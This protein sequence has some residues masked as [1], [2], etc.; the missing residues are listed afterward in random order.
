[1]HERAPSPPDIVC[2]RAPEK[3]IRQPPVQD[4]CSFGPP[5]RPGGVNDI[6]CIPGPRTS[7][8]ACPLRSLERGIRSVD[9]LRIHEGDVHRAEKAGQ[10]LRGDHVRRARVF[11]NEPPAIFRERGIER[12]ICAP[13]FEDPEET[14]HHFA[15]PL[16]R[17]PHHNLRSHAECRQ[18]A[19]EEVCTIVQV[20]VAPR[21]APAGDRHGLR[22]QAGLSLDELVDTQGWSPGDPGRVPLQKYP[23][24]FLRGQERDLPHAHIVPARRHRRQYRLEMPQHPFDGRRGETRPGVRQAQRA[25]LPLNLKH[26]GEARMGEDG[27]LAFA[28]PGPPGFHERGQ[29]DVIIHEERLKKRRAA[30]HLAPRADPPERC[31]FVLTDGRMILPHLPQ[32]VSQE[33]LRREADPEGESVDAAPE[34]PLRTVHRRSAAG[35]R[36]AE[37]DVGCSTVA[38]EQES[39]GCV[40]H[41]AQPCPR[42]SGQFT[43]PGKDRGGKADIASAEFKECPRRCTG[44]G[45]RGKRCRLCE[46]P[47]VVLP[48]QF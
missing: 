47:E 16:Q 35:S 12:E 7:R 32:Q 9:L 40:E 42:C 30:G 29:S 18:P 25:F 13:G 20:P 19:R 46:S 36:L 43:Q 5:R 15:R 2:L 39:P 33:R 28:P 26:Q 14:H 45:L 4:N 11:E 22:G 27:E 37:Y 34:D 24:F 48:E 8:Q 31:L 17:D 38:T 21:V 44:S 10:I 41:G 3:V 6:G 1:M 23:P